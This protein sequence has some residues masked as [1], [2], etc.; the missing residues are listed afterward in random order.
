VS[1]S[2]GF[3]GSGYGVI[4]GRVYPRWFVV[5]RHGVLLYLMDSGIDSNNG[6]EYKPCLCFHSCFLLSNSAM[7]PS[8]VH[9]RRYSTSTLLYSFVYSIERVA[10]SLLCTKL[11]VRVSLVLALQVQST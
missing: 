11:V 5:S 1:S 7:P 9:V 6:N 2:I 3:F 4:G 8:T 10:A